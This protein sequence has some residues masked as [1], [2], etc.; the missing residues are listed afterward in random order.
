MVEGRTF[1]R[2][3]R[4]NS[5]STYVG[6]EKVK[7]T[8]R[9]TFNRGIFPQV[10]LVIGGTGLGKTTLSRIIMKEY[11]CT[12]REPGKDA[13][14][15]C[16]SCKDFDE[17]IRT[18][19]TEN[20]PDVEEIN[21]AEQSSKSAVQDILEQRIYEPMHQ[22]RKYYYL[23]EVHKANNALQSY[24]LKPIEEPEPHV[25]YILATTD[26]DDLLDTIK[27]RANL[28]LNIKK[29]TEIEVARQLG[30]ICEREGIE[31][32]PE[33]FR[34]IAVKS[35]F[36]FRESLNT[37]QQIVDGYGR[38]FADDV[39]KEFDLATDDIMF[40]FFDSYLRRDYLGYL[41]TLHE[42]KSTSGINGFMDSVMTFISRGIY[43]INGV[44]L[45]GITREEIRKYTDLFSKFRIHDLALILS[46]LT[47]IS[48]QKNLEAELM[49]FIYLQNIDELSVKESHN[50]EVESNQNPTKPISITHSDEAKARKRALSAKE[51]K[52][53]EK[54][55]T[56]L[57]KAV[58]EV[59]ILEGLEGI[60]MS[61]II[62]ETL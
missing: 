35:D 55:R 10:I 16:D 40:R 42:A 8:L 17:Y 39:A 49:N 61:R 47:T 25:V 50:I 37:L 38:C 4:P 26:P 14:G 15:V 52:K 46:R 34:L 29:P 30:V 7:E 56:V 36:V 45:E 48:K 32:E 51:D 54:G 62:E 21:V 23:D 53:V 19:S 20:L 9:N 59:S 1:A 57:A 33:A 13:C 2:E 58:E 12:N 43:I 41:S 11:E 6:N 5:L 18:G 27:N 31:Y 60:P 44:D 3:Y 22:S 28:V 24:L